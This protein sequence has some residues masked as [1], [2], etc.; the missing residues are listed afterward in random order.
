MNPSG[1]SL[2]FNN[3]CHK[4][5]IQF[6]PEPDNTH[7]TPNQTDSSISCSGLLCLPYQMS[8]CIQVWFEYSGKGLASLLDLMVECQCFH[9]GNKY[10]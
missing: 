8:F 4:P 10:T 3:N 1:V 5:G 2:P 7:K 6:S 9:G